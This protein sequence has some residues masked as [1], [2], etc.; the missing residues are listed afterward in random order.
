MWLQLTWLAW[1]MWR[2]NYLLNYVVAGEVARI[3]YRTCKLC[4]KLCGCRWDGQNKL[5]DSR[6]Q[7]NFAYLGVRKENREF[8]FSKYE[9]IALDWASWSINKL[10]NTL[11][12]SGGKCTHNLYH[13][14]L[15][16]SWENNAVGSFERSEVAIES[17]HCGD[18]DWWMAGSSGF[19]FKVHVTALLN[20]GN[21]CLMSN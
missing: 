2:K 5:R 3:N 6:K 12:R 8:Q 19:Q 21:D 7:S 20:T 1:I 17:L 14:C 9:A 4:C 13:F 16:G 18:C 11:D 15:L 10:R